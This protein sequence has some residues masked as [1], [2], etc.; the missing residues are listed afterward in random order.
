MILAYGILA[1]L[2]ILIVAVLALVLVAWY[3]MSSSKQPSPAAKTDV[4]T[5]PIVQRFVSNDLKKRAF[6][7][8]L[9]GHKP[10][11][12]SGRMAGFAQEAGHRFFSQCS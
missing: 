9:N 4:K 2:I 11:R 3:L 7:I 5:Q 8:Q 12:R 10:G 1:I 6:V